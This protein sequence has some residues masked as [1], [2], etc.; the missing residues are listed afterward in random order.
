MLDL[1][2]NKYWVNTLSSS[3]LLGTRD[4]RTGQIADIGYHSFSILCK[5]QWALHHFPLTVQQ[6]LAGWIGRCQQL[7][8]CWSMLH[9][10]VL[11]LHA[12]VHGH[13][14]ACDWHVCKGS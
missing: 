9:A 10:L 7:Q 6:A 11:V 12:G 1:L 2:W 3:P 8:L 13:L 5:P 14:Q 4:L